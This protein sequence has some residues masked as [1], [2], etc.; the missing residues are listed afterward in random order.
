MVTDF[1][2]P[3]F[4]RIDPTMALP[5]RP[6]PSAKGWMVS[7]WAWA[8]ADCVSAGTSSRTVNS[9]RSSRASGSRSWWGGTKSAVCG[10]L[11]RIHT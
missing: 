2:T 9:A 1:V 4:R 7:N 10:E 3:L 5:V 11:P 6:L 8:I